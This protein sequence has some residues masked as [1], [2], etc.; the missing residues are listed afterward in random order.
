MSR[1]DKATT[2]KHAKTLRE[3]LKRPENKVCA[4]C[5]RND[6]RWASWNIGVFLCIRCSGIHR[7]MGT[8]IS[9]VKSVDLD[10]WTPEQMASIQK[11]GNRLANLYWEAHLRSGHI[12]ADHKMDSFI[13]SKYESK[14]WAMEG[15]P[16]ADPS[17]LDTQSA[18]AP[19]PAATIPAQ[20]TQATSRSQTPVESLVTVSASRASITNRQPQPHQLLST[21]IANRNQQGAAAST[22]SA[23]QAQQH[24]P[25]LQATPTPSNDLFSLDFNAP[26]STPSA[27]AASAPRKDVKQDILSL[28]S[29]PA[30]QLAAPQTAP[31]PMAFGQFGQLT[32]AQTAWSPWDSQA[33]QPAAQSTNVVGHAASGSMG[34]GTT[35]QAPAQ[36]NIWGAP[37]AQP[38]VQ[39]QSLFTTSDVWGSS[40]GASTGGN[41]IFGS[42]LPGMQKK[43][44][45]FGDIWGGFK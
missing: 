24:T 6:P 7:S 36:P 43:D 32:Q 38:A 44:D 30:A 28:F 26:A 17:T 25:Q 20:T 10:V 19:V 14:R 13:R 39:Q 29:T 16:P 8:H 31:A 3:L 2:E 35:P 23:P 41:E 42:P 40:G 4:D 45:A 21:S 12:P 11:W 5:K 34:W 9:K 33:T 15:P 1:Q 27:P 37:A 18:A 22:I